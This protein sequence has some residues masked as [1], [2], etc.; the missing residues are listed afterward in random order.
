MNNKWRI[1]LFIVHRGREG[2]EGETS[3]LII[4][5]FVAD[6]SNSPCRL[7][8]DRAGVFAQFITPEKKE[9]RQ[10]RDSLKRHL[11]RVRWRRDET[12]GSSGDAQGRSLPLYERR[13]VMP[14]SRSP[15]FVRQ[16]NFHWSRRKAR[17][18]YAATRRR[19]DDY[20]LISIFRSFAFGP[21]PPFH[22]D[23]RTRAPTPAYRR[24]RVS[25]GRVRG[26][27]KKKKRARRKGD[28][29]EGES[30]RNTSMRPRREITRARH[31]GWRKRVEATRIAEWTGAL[32]I[33]PARE[34]VFENYLQNS[35]IGRHARWKCKR[36]G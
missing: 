21:S 17:G 9:I 2:E 10:A 35:R 24:E 23:R 22:S 7:I 4:Y 3:C 5:K 15:L 31:V 26:C 25:A 12:R 28:D 19:R 32:R 29:D 18:S 16:A 8:L 34:L 33:S 6:N 14:S 11:S 1:A 36:R 20:S 27:E 13:V 30:V